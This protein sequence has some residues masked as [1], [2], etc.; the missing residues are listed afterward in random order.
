MTREFCGRAGQWSRRL[1]RSGR[2]AWAVACLLL[3]A[4]AS[5]PDREVVHDTT[6]AAESPGGELVDRWIVEL[7]EG[8]APAEVLHAARM[9]IG[10]TATI[11]PLFL[12]AATERMARMFVVRSA[13][14]VDEPAAWDAARRMR[15]LGNFVRV[16]PNLEDQS[17]PQERAAAAACTFESGVPAPSD[18]SWSLREIRVPEAWAL[19]P[20]PGGLRFGEGVRVCHPDTGWTEHVE[21]DQARLDL[22]A[23]VD[24]VDGA[25]P[26]HDP[27]G[28]AGHP[29]HGTATG[30]VIASGGGTTPGVGTTPPGR[31][32]GVAPGATL[33]PIRAIRS[34][35]RFLDSNVARAVAHAQQSQCDVVSMSLGGRMFFG[36]E[37]AIESAVDDDMLVVAAAGNCVG[38]MVAPAVYEDTIAAAATNA[39]RQPWNGSSRGRAVTISAPGEDVY[40]ARRGRG[41]DALDLVEA[42]NGTSFATAEVAG[43]AALWIAFHGRSRLRDAKGGHRLHDLFVWALQQSADNLGA[44]WDERRFGAGILDVD[45][46][47]RVDLAAFPRD[48]VRRAT[49]SDRQL[50]LIARSLDISDRAASR[51]LVN[52]FGDEDPELL[53]ERYGAELHRH[54]VARPALFEGLRSAAERRA[55]GDT[56]QRNA[57]GLSTSLRAALRE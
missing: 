53:A 7:D 39:A 28:Y 30:S 40:V 4:C 17:P 3:G 44:S 51:L 37:A 31:V 35:V 12:D 5:T 18:P 29:G 24:L 54:L 21:T 10:E 20:P 14:P 23:A 34:V 52:L 41:A 50:S 25:G 22:S 15:E 2:L 47:L 36:L 6:G 13:V 8:Q 9:G 16:E 38:F 49:S 57:T 1:R 26:A 43:A 46:L 11:E 33:V 27:L 42:S 45:A 48:N 56:L 32:T 55:T 19:L